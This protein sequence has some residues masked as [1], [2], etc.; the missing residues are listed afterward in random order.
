MQELDLG[1]C[2]GKVQQSRLE[3]RIGMRIAEDYVHR[4]GQEIKARY[5]GS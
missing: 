5:V 4:T 2:D 3:E 1:S